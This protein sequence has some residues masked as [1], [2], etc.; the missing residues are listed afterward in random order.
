MK[1]AVAHSSL[2]RFALFADC[3][4]SP[5][6]RG[7]GRQMIAE[8]LRAT[9]NNQQKTAKA[10]GLSRQGLINKLKRYRLSSVETRFFGAVS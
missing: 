6:G 5:A 1:A 2:S 10:R 8:M 4:N 7:T 3:V 9:G